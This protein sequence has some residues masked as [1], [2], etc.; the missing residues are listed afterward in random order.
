MLPDDVQQPDWEFVLVFYLKDHF[1]I[2]VVLPDELIG[3]ECS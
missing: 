1:G 3:E 2:Q